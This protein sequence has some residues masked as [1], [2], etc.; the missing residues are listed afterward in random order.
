MPEH[1]QTAVSYRPV[2]LSASSDDL[3]LGLGGQDGGGRLAVYSGCPAPGGAKR[4]RAF[5]GDGFGERVAPP[6]KGV[7][8]ITP[9]I[10]EFTG[11]KSCILAHLDIKN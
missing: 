1:N 8:G 3:C 6:V 4:R 5:M 9:T 2:F 10:F 11:A 7:W